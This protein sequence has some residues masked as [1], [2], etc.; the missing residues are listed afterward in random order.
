MLCLRNNVVPVH[1]PLHLLAS[2]G[3]LEGE[4]LNMFER[5]IDQNSL[6]N[7]GLS[8]LSNEG[9]TPFCEAILYGNINFIDTL[10]RSEASFNMNWLDVIDISSIMVQKAICKQ[11]SI[12]S[13]TAF[14]TRNHSSE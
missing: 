7:C 4:D 11:F 12:P 14:N 8:Q 2:L 5:L 9:R 13:L 6:Q 10:L 1:G 3:K